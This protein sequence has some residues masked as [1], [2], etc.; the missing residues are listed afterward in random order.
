M[1]VW[2][3]VGLL[4][5]LVWGAE[6][7]IRRQSCTIKTTTQADV[8]Y[9]QLDELAQEFGAACYP[10][11][12]GWSL[13]PDDAEVESGKVRVGKALLETRLEDGLVYVNAAEFCLAL[14]GKVSYP[15]RTVV[16]LTPPES[17]KG[18]VKVDR[19]DP[20]SFFFT[21]VRSSTNA[22]SGRSNG[23]CAPA[24][25]SMVA[26]AFDRWPLGVSSENRQGMMTWVRREMGADRN[27]Q[28]GT[29][30]G[31]MPPVA[32]KLKL[33]PKWV[34]KF[35]DIAPHVA[36]GR[37][38]IVGGDMSRLG[39]PPGGHAMLV[40]GVDG[41]DYLLNDPG[42]FYKRPGTRI[43]AAD[44]QRFFQLGLALGNN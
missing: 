33:N 35:E 9:A 19:N 32:E 10:A 17:S 26:L 41:G 18:P 43:K 12:S 14:G 1:K 21:Q 30:I 20:S 22:V 36:K 15:E 4:S 3:F 44:L 37:L 42:L 34:T 39:F 38:V 24:C 6:L 27:E 40:V 2:L 7:Q 29:N 31:T 25:L 13:Q 28:M 5:T 23:N 16:N 8:L 11:G